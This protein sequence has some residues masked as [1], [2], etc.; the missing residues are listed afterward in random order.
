MKL[1]H[2]PYEDLLEQGKMV[3]DDGA[4]GCDDSVKQCPTVVFNKCQ[5]SEC[6]DEKYLQG[7][8]LALYKDLLEKMH[9]IDEVIKELKICDPDSC[10]IERRE[11]C[12]YYEGPE[13][14]F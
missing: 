2:C 6:M 8:A 5:E 12:P 3:C 14:D 10:I 7:Q 9:K 11:Q 1:F 4:L 13:T